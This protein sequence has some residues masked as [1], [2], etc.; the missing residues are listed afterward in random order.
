[1]C[2][3]WA[4][5]RGSRGSGWRCEQRL[6]WRCRLYAKTII[7]LPGQPRDKHREK[8]PKERMR[9]FAGA[10]TAPGER[11][12]G[13]ENAFLRSHF[14]LNIIILPR[15]ARDKRRESTQKRDRFAQVECLSM[16]IEKEWGPLLASVV[17]GA[18]CTHV[19]PEELLLQTRTVNPS[20]SSGGGSTSSTSSSSGT[21]TSTSTSSSTSSGSASTSSSTSSKTAAGVAAAAIDCSAAAVAAAAVSSLRHRV[22]FVQSDCLTGHAGPDLLSAAPSVDV[23]TFNY[24]MVE[25]AKALRRD[26]F[27][28]LRQVFAA[29]RI[30]AVFVFM[31]AAYHLWEETVAVFGGLEQQP[32]TT[33]DSTAG[34]GGGMQFAVLHPH[35]QPWQCKSTMLVVKLR[36][37]QA[38]K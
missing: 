21:S 28:Y 23:F 6:F 38:S 13:A 22:A 11:G 1:V 10:G 36:A 26:K 14:I 9:F 30:G 24:C 5:A 20:S 12:V 15:Q 27:G 17:A 31:D 4:A 25:N 29:A 16:D 33:T 32:N 35:P 19:P 3:R 2:R 34:G 7:N 37:V 18:G 8:H